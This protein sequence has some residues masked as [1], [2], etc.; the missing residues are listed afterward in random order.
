MKFEITETVEHETITHAANVSDSLLHFLLIGVFVGSEGSH[1][2]I[3]KHLEEASE[4][5]LSDS[6]QIRM[7]FDECMKNFTVK[8]VE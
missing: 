8:R 2:R 3:M 7:E 5:N 1:F 6:M 4:L